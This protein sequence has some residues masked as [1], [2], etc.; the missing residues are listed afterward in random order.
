MGETPVQYIGDTN[1]VKNVLLRGLRSGTM[2]KYVAVLISFLFSSDMICIKYTGAVQ[3][4]ILK[5]YTH[6]AL[7]RSSCKEWCFL[8]DQSKA[9]GF[10]L[11]TT[12]KEKYIL[13]SREHRSLAGTL[14]TCTYIHVHVHVHPT[15]N[16][17]RI[18]SVGLVQT[19]PN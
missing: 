1:H 9:V 15:Q 3:K 12:S 8:R 2:Y 16:S 6:S 10:S 19:R 17:I 18:A 13:K 14:C 7:A 4:R 11:S 5:T